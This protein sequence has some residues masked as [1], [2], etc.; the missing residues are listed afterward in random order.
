MTTLI[1]TNPDQIPV[2]SM[3]GGMAYQDP[4]SINVKDFNS[5][6]T[7]NITNLSYSGTLTGGTGVINIGS[8]QIYKDAGGN[9]GI[10]NSPVSNGKTLTLVNASTGNSSFYLQNST[11]GFTTTDGTLLQ[12]S[13][14][15]SYLWNFENSTLS[16]AT[17]NTEYVRLTSAGDLLNLGTG[18]TKLQEGTT[19]QRPASPQ[20]GMIRKNSTTGRIESY[21]RGAWK[22]LSEEGAGTPVNLFDNA[23]F[24]VENR[25]RATNSAGANTS[26]FITDRWKW[27]SDQSSASTSVNFAT[28]STYGSES[29][30]GEALVIANNT[31]ITIPSTAQ[32]YF[33]Q[34]AMVYPISIAAGFV[35]LSF[36][37][38]SNVT[39]TFPVCVIH[40]GY[41]F[42]SSFTISEIGTLKRFTIKIPVHPLAPYGSDSGLYRVIFPMGFGSSFIAPYT[43]LWENTSVRAA[44]SGTT[45]LLTL[46]P[47]T[48]LYFAEMQL[49]AGEVA[50]PFIRKDP[51]L[52]LLA[53]LQHYQS[54]VLPMAGFAGTVEGAVLASPAATT[55]YA[56][57]GT[58]QL[59]SELLY[60]PSITVYNPTSGAAGTAR[61]LTA[62][63]DVAV[64]ILASSIKAFSLRVNNVSV[65]AN[66]EVYAHWSAETGY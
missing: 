40:L 35:T 54:S 6:G 4:D 58:I 31:A 8:N 10:G 7:A 42:L 14:S 29:F 66:S 23:G 61:N 64:Q 53:C 27:V 20:E 2:N 59:R 63:S 30:F 65:T 52:D 17:N 47:G 18:A 19:A 43:G 24:C 9:V 1:G 11:T 16:L 50:T 36:K 26:L 21:I 60:T 34:A 48:S 45:S 49:E 5:S 13:G 28:T 44:T 37:A 38:G 25:P 33:E 39:G 46:S 3:L 41:R 62:S 57:F 55:N 51:S 12:L 22:N 32:N 56:S 15:A